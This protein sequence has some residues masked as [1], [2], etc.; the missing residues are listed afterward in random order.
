[1]RTAS[2]ARERAKVLGTLAATLLVALAA[3]AS[4]RGGVLAPPPGQVFFG[5]S[6]TGVASQFNEFGELVGKH[7]AVIETFRTWG[8]DLMGSVRRWQ[9]AEARPIVHISTADPNDGHELI[10]P[11]G[12][13]FGYGDDYLINLN[14]L[15]WSRGMRAYVRPLGEPNRCLNVYAAYDC[16]G[17]LRGGAHRTYW[18]KQAFRRI[19]IVLHG[20]GSVATIDARL[21]KIGLPPLRSAAGPLPEALPAAPVAVIW[22]PLPTGSPATKGNRPER[23]FPGAAYTDWAGTDFYSGYPEW[24]AL[25]HLYNRYRRK[26]FVLT[27]WGVEG[28][29]DPVFVKRLFAWARRHPRCKMLVYYQDFGASNSYRI[30]NFPA[31]LEVLRRR[32]ASPVFPA[33]AP[34]P[35]QLPPPPPGGVAP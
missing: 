3:A 22:S 16:E 35:P 30:Q 14:Y 13:A 7:P 34:A 28:V 25:T 10:D 6:D 1:M 21:A 2:R 5:V 17:N 33:Y 15:F 18:Y 24:K 20:G 27:E 8:T 4:A 11:R 9:E 29:D 19:Y 12:I 26:P 23:F 31:S 32:L